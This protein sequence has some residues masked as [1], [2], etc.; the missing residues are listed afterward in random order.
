MVQDKNKNFENI[1]KLPGGL[2]DFN[3][4]IQQ[5]VLREVKEETGINCSFQKVL[6]FRETS[7]Y[8]FD[9]PDIY[10]VCL[11]FPLDF[12]I[13]IQQSEIKDCKWVDIGQIKEMLNLIP[14]QRMLSQ[15]LS[16]FFNTNN[17]NALNHHTYK[18]NK[19]TNVNTLYYPDIYSLNEKDNSKL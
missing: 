19:N 1:W 13:V 6:C 4:S 15:I 7:S 9:C 11:L 5:A 10:F 18:N 14:I 17:L 3:E 16:Q 8:Q 12:N 2:A